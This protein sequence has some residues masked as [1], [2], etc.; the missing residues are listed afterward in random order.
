V[1]PRAGLDTVVG[2]EKPCSAED[3]IWVVQP[4]ASHFTDYVMSQITVAVVVV[5]PFFAMNASKLQLTIF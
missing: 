4:A 5:V 2:R 3:L 1:G